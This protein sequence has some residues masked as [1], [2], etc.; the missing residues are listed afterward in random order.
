MNILSEPM[1]DDIH[2]CKMCGDL[3]TWSER[4]GYYTCPECTKLMNEIDEEYVAKGGVL[5]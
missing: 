1:R 4:D 5:I 3:G 2:E